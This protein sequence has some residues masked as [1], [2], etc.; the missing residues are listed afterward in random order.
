[1]AGKDRRAYINRI[2]IIKGANLRT[3]DEIDI[4]QGA[5]LTFEAGGIKILGGS[6]GVT[7]GSNGELLL[8]PGTV[9]QKTG[10]AQGTEQMIG[11]GGGSI[12]PDGR[13]EDWSSYKLTLSVPAF[14]DAEYGYT[15]KAKEITITNTGDSNATISDITISGSAFTLNPG[16]KL[17]HTDHPNNTWTIQPKAGLNAG[18]YTGTLTVTYNGNAT[19]FAEVKFTV[20]PLPVPTYPVTINGGE[21][22]GTY[23]VGE[24]SRLQPL[25]RKAGIL[26]DG[27]WM[28]AM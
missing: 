13:V 26:P 7:V 4:S 21:G 5:S 12:S 16:D 3:G 25:S 14:E 1:M 6:G 15:P 11:I 23:G 20:K 27:Q 24:K 10:D 18:T 22:S 28:R 8:P 2:F 17:V 19:A 9:L